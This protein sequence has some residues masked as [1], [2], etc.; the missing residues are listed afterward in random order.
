[1]PNF[2]KEDAQKKIIYRTISPAGAVLMFQREYKENLIRSIPP[3]IVLF[4]YRTWK[5]LNYNIKPNIL[6]NK[7]KI[8]FNKANKLSSIT[9]TPSWII[10]GILLPCTNK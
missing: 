9:F 5:D 1:M 7:D 4:I 2:K 8:G 6:L 3:E 10:Y